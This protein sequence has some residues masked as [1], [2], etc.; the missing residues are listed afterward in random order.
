MQLPA[1]L[2]DNIYSQ[3]RATMLVDPNED[4]RVI[5]DDLIQHI[6][7]DPSVKIV[8]RYGVECVVTTEEG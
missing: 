7:A 3:L 8:E 4:T 6:D 2:V 5:L 1:Y